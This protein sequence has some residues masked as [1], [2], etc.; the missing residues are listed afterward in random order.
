MAS[1][2]G[3]S[4]EAM[5]VD[6]ASNASAPSPDLLE[7]LPPLTPLKK[8]RL[9]LDIMPPPS[10]YLASHAL[11]YEKEDPEVTDEV[12]DEV[13]EIEPLR[14]NEHD[15]VRVLGNFGRPL[16]MDRKCMNYESC[17]K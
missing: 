6:T 5:E 13:M 9:D 15:E 8:I 12:T 3:K 7:I 2:D 16:L 1:K 14:L 11:L 10:M 17:M 4:V